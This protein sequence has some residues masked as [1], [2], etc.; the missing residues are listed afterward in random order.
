MG[1]GCREG[2]PLWGFIPDTGWP[3]GL[4]STRL[5]IEGPQAGAPWGWPG[6]AFQEVG[7]PHSPSVPALCFSASSKSARPT[8]PQRTSLSTTCWACPPPRSSSWAGPPRS[9][10]PSARWVE[11]GL[12]AGSCEGGQGKGWREW[13][14][15]SF[16]SSFP[17]WLIHLFSKHFGVPASGQGLCWVR[18]ENPKWSR[19]Q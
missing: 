6:K 13:A 10:K 8:A 9:T 14:L 12:E 16:M 4:E 18:G 5:P 17:H 19:M 1:L 15:H 3:H 7:W 2:Q 11:A